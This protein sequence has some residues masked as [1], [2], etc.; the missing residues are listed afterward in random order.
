[1]AHEAWQGNHRTRDD[2]VLVTL[3]A[4]NTFNAAKWADNL[5]ALEQRFSVPPYQ[6]RVIDDYLQDRELTCETTKGQIGNR[7]TAGV[8]LGPRKVEWLGSQQL[9]GTG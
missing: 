4:K 3:G 1:M 7:V 5:E 6:L 2:C 8:A 9:S